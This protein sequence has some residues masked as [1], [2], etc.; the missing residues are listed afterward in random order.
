MLKQNRD[1]AIFELKGNALESKLQEL[2]AGFSSAVPPSKRT[3]KKR[4]AILHLYY[5][6][7]IHNVEEIVEKT[8]DEYEDIVR[9]KRFIEDVLHEVE[10]RLEVQ[11]RIRSLPRSLCVGDKMLDGP[12]VTTIHGQKKQMDRLL[13]EIPET[14]ATGKKTKKRAAKPK[15]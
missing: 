6:K 1:A 14:K 5:V 11:E 13:R 9:C 15:P 3:I 12:T 2:A 7:G 8:K 10:H 4:Y